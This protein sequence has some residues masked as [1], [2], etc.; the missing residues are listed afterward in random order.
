[1]LSW[2]RSAEPN[3]LED[4]IKEDPRMPFTEFWQRYLNAHR[5]PGTRVAHYAATLLG[6]SSTVV[7]IHQADLT[8][9]VGG[10]MVSVAIAVGSHWLI[11]GNQPLILVNPFYGAIADLRMC[12]L[13]LTGGLDSEYK[14]RL[15]D[16][17]N[18]RPTDG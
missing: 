5:R 7:T 2:A 11:E 13:A 6:A 17:A 15:S 4:H 9:M 18:S 8:Y 12:W 3:R 16:A 14:R 10:I 1:V